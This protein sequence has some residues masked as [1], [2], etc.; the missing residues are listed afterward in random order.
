MKPV[1]VLSDVFS[2]WSLC[3][4]LDVYCRGAERRLVKAPCMASGIFSFDHSL[5]QDYHQ[6]FCCTIRD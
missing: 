4:R 5:A 3:G 2:V 1:Q 6:K